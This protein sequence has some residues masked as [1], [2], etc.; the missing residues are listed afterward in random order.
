MII[1]YERVS[2]VDQNLERQTKSLEK[3]NCDIIINDKMSGKNTERP[4]F[5]K[6]MEDLQES[7]TVVVMSYSRLSRSTSDL[8]KIVDE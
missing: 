8:L 7:D 5:L 6:M 4:N 2:T 3:Y 1:G